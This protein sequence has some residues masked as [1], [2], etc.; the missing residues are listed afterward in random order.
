[1]ENKYYTPEIE[2]F[3]VGFEYEEFEIVGSGLEVPNIIIKY[4]EEYFNEVHSND[5]YFKHRKFIRK[6]CDK[7]TVSL[8]SSTSFSEKY[9]PLLIDN[10]IRV[11]YLD[12]E[13]IESFG[14]EYINN[15][16]DLA[17][18]NIRI[19]TYIGEQFEIPTICIYRD[20]NTIF[21]GTIKNKTDFKRLLKQLSIID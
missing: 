12:K 8:F 11:K 20:E 4:S 13:D 14:F 17:K 16:R 21:S 19:R 5:K 7:Q 15:V 1:M 18:D 10:R 3:H 9:T 6:V 2:E